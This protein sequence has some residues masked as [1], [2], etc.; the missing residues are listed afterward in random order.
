MSDFWEGFLQGVKETPRGFFAPLVAVARIVK[1]AF[2]QLLDITDALV[3]PNTSKGR[4]A[5]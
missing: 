5:H 1:W 4:H 2:Q 3:K